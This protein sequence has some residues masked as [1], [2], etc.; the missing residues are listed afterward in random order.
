MRA[1]EVLGRDGARKGS[2]RGRQCRRRARGAAVPEAGPRGRGRFRTDGGGRAV[3]AWIQGAMGITGVVFVLA[4]CGRVER[5]YVPKDAPVSATSTGPS[6]GGTTEPSAGHSTEP[7]SVPSDGGDAA[8]SAVP[9]AVASLTPPTPGVE[10]VSLGDQVRVRIEW[11]AGADPRLRLVADYYLNSRRAVVTGDDRY[12]GNLESEAVGQAHEWVSEFAKQE[13]SLRGVARLYNLRIQAVVGRAVQVNTCVD[14]SRLRLISTRT[15]KAVAR[16]P[17]W[18]REPYMQAVAAR[19]GDDGV[20]RIRTF[21][22]GSEG[23]GR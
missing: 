8:P 11:P 16:Q 15:G 20:W 12:L 19:R 9:S 10:T 4:G 3:K 17:E 2:A 5:P 13:R 14:E 23:C 6:A 18:T 22:H 1:A 7:G 21:V